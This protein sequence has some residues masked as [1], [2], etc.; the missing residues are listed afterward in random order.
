MTTIHKT[1]NTT[2]YR[3][4]LLHLTNQPPSA[5]TQYASEVF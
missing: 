5:N 2:E 3:H 4:H 1:Y